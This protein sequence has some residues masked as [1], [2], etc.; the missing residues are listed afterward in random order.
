MAPDA[1]GERRRRLEQ[2]VAGA[3]ARLSWE[4]L[5]SSHAPE[6]QRTRGSCPASGSS[7]AP[8]ASCAAPPP[9]RPQ[10]RPRP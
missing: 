5:G 2:S 1:G 8:P 3:E 4:M 9:R 6:P 7:G 10:P